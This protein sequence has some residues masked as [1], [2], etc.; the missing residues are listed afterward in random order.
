MIKRS[1]GRSSVAAAAYR[2][3]EKLRSERDS[4]VNA[5]AYRSGEKL[6]EYDYTRKQGVVHTEILLPENAP[7][8]YSDRAA[9]WNAVEQAEKRKDAQTARDIDIALPIELDRQEQIA[10]VR[11]YVKQN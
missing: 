8:D 10:L 1:S 7:Q 5:A 4:S 2:S 9:L 11:E 6:G 3:A